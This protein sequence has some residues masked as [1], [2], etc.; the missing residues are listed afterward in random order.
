MK[1]PPAF[2][3][4]MLVALKGI[5]LFFSY[6]QLRLCTGCQDLLFSKKAYEKPL[7]RLYMRMMRPELRRYT[8]KKKILLNPGM[9]VGTPRLNHEPVHRR[10]FRMACGT[11]R[12][13]LL[14]LSS[15][16]SLLAGSFCSYKP[17]QSSLLSFQKDNMNTGIRLYVYSNTCRGH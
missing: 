12:V 4:F 10:G 7:S 6:R 17:P 9:L 11:R 2:S 16:G 13:A 14:N 5:M 8:P 15:S 3:S 1:M